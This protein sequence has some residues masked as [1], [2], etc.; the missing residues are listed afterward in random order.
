VNRLAVLSTDT[1]MLRYSPERSR[2]FYEQA[3]TKVMAIPGVESAALATRV[4][5]QV[6]TNRWETKKN[7]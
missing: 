5:L 7:L 2:Q 1:A 4:P 6:N 3:I